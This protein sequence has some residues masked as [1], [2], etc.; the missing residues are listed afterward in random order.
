MAFVAVMMFV[1]VVALLCV[2]A[3]AATIMIRRKPVTAVTVPFAAVTA[4]PPST[5]A[6]TDGSAVSE[7]RSA[8]IDATRKAADARAAEEAAL[9]KEMTE[10]AAKKSVVEPFIGDELSGYI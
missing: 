10:L 8:Q 2:G 3:W 7:D 5:A 4:P 9:H 1:M 6:A